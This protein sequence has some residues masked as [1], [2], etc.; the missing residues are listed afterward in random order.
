MEQKIVIENNAEWGPVEKAIY[1]AIRTHARDLNPSYSVI[2]A[3]AEK[4]GDKGLLKI[5]AN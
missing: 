4:L 2:R 1:E 3:I 5:P